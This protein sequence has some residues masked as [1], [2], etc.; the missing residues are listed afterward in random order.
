MKK[1]FIALFSIVICVGINAQNSSITVRNNFFTTVKNSETIDIDTLLIMPDDATTTK[2]F[3]FDIAYRKFTNDEDGF[4]FRLGMS[5]FLQ[6][7]DETELISNGANGYREITFNQSSN[8]YFTGLGVFHQFFKSDK[9]TATA[10]AEAIF[11]YQPKTSYTFQVH[12]FNTEREFAGGNELTIGIP[13]TI[14]GGLN[15]SSNL[16][17]QLFSNF[18]VGLEA[19]LQFLYENQKGNMFENPKII[20]DKGDVADELDIPHLIKENSI[21][22]QFY[23]SLGL[24]YQF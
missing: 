5:K 15:L 21:S 19:N 18:S 24:Q 20:D 9:I 8:T 7:R 13:R 12:N 14:G 6:K 16:Y 22:R 17:Y 2:S 23:V 3:G 11:S 10:N 4:I 1:S